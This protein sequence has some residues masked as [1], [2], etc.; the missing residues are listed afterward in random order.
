[1]KERKCK[2]E[3]FGK[4]IEA[5]MVMD[6]SVVLDEVL[7]RGEISL[8]F[9]LEK[10]EGLKKWAEEYMQKCS[11]EELEILSVPPGELFKAW[12]EREEALKKQGVE[13]IPWKIEVKNEG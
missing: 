13:V 3:M 5:V 6:D 10:S 4:E 8:T 1:M 2:I 7:A 12:E 9:D 11:E